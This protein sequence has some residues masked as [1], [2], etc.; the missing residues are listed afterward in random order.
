MYQTYK[1]I[2]KTRSLDISAYV[3]WNITTNTRFYTNLNGGYNYLS[4]G[5]GLSNHGWM[6]FYYAG[7]QQTFPYDWR[8]GISTS[9][10]T[11]YISLQG[12]GSSF[13]S[14]GVNVY[15][16]FID[17]R[18]TFSLFANDFFTPKKKSSSTLESANFAYNSW[19]EYSSIRYGVS[20]SFRI[21]KLTA[22][23]KKAARTITNDDVKGGGNN[24][25]Q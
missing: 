10:Q 3:N 16:S 5:N 6:L 7:L 15:K 1:N 22:S 13:F 17:K 9:G 12:K 21:G 23:V 24:G 19:Y 11:P 18:L 2:G 4:D 14:Y 20:V 8:I 25:Q